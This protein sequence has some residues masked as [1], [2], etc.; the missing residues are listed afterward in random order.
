GRGAA[1]ESALKTFGSYL[2]RGAGGAAD[3]LRR[4]VRSSYE[5]LAYDAYQ[6]GEPRRARGYLRAAARAP[7]NTERRD[8]DHNLAVLDLNQGL[9]RAAERVFEQLGGK[10]AEA[11][12]NLGIVRDRQGDSKKALELYRRAQERGAR[13][14]KLKEWIDVKERLLEARL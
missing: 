9:V 7:A 1:R 5:L 10:P 4:L 12:V 11:L 6:R 14:P 8:L 2:A 3:W 13:A